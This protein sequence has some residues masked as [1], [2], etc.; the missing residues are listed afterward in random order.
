MRIGAFELQEPLPELREPHA[1]TMLR[2]WV[3][4]GSV[5]SLALTR[6]ERHLQA[7]ELGK[8]ARPGNFF[9][10]TRYRPMLSTQDGARVVTVPNSYVNY[11]R[12]ADGHDFVFLHLLEPHMFG[13]DYTDSVVQLLKEIGVKRYVLVGGMYDA[14]PH[15]RPLMVTGSIAGHLTKQS[16]E[17]AKVETS[18][19]QGP[20]TINYLTN[21]QAA[22]AGIETA[23]LIVH[24]PQYAQLD[25]DFHGAAKILDV[26]CNMYGFPDNIIDR[27]R[28][29]AQYAEITKAVNARMRPVIQQLERNY[30]ARQMA[31]QQKRDD[32]PLS[33]EIEKF[34]RQIDESFDTGDEGKRK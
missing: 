17:Q 11:A 34:L 32:A 30:D 10:F 18:T 7:H 29:E 14:V 8:L 12:R 33:P 20:T 26:L 21:Q 9:D 23:S 31:E 3:D 13:E 27:K 15:T 5:G 2:P 25:E 22:A 4:V 1:L 24:L 28:G 6:V 16:A 19:Y